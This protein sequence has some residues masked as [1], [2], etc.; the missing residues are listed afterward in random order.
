MIVK[1]QRLDIFDATLPLGKTSERQAGNRRHTR[2]VVHLETE[3][4]DAV[5]AKHL[6]ELRRTKSFVTISPPGSGRMCLCIHP[7]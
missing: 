1:E 3:R 4:W 5:G 7:S 6:K 2:D